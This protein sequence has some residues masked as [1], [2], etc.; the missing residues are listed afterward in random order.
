MSEAAVA[1]A[2]ML[3]PGSEEERAKVAAGLAE[4]ERQLDRINDTPREE[5]FATVLEELRA[6]DGPTR[7]KVVEAKADLARVHMRMIDSMLTR[8]AIMQGDYPRSL[9]ELSEDVPL[10]PWGNPYH[11][12]A[13]DEDSFEYRIVCYGADGKPGGQGPDADI[14]HAR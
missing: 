5:R 10:D 3:R 13:P 1:F 9:G 8:H 11:Y 14:E 6:L 12:Q 4:A 7:A 2:S